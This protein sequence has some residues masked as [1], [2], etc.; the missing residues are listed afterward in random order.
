MPQPFSTKL[1]S[2]LNST[3]VKL[4]RNNLKTLKI[5][6]LYSQKQIALKKIKPHQLKRDKIEKGIKKQ[7]HPLSIN[8]RKRL[9]S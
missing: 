1:A 7:Q 9:R 6:T 4:D 2:Y 5:Q 8:T 3:F